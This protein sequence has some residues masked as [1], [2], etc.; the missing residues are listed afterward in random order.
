VPVTQAATGEERRLH[1]SR[2]EQWMNPVAA[3]ISNQANPEKKE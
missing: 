3:N 2:P 1:L